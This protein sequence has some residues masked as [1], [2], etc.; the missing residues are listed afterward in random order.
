VVG[1]SSA[2]R[3]PPPLEELGGW[4]AVLR[5]LFAGEVL[6]A[7]VAEAALTDVLSGGAT[8]VQLAAFVGALRARGERVE[9]VAGFV[10][11]MRRHAEQVPV[12]GELVD[13]CGTGGDQSG[14]INVSTVAALVVAAAG[15]RV[16]KHGGRAAS[17]SAGSADVLEALGVVIDLGPAGVARCIEETGIGFCFAPRF[18]PAMRHAAPVRREL[19][20]PTVF[21]LLGPLSNPARATRQV[22]GVGDPALAEVVL[23]ALVANG[24]VHAM[25][26]YGLDGLDELS[27]GAP[28]VVLESEQVAPGRHEQRR[29]E[30]DPSALGIARASR[31]SLRGG[32]A[33]TNAR[34]A[35]EVLGGAPGPHREVVC[36]N[37][38][39]GLLVADA[40]GDWGEALERARA[41][42][43]D[44]SAKRLLERFVESSRRAAEDGLR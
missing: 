14:S 2:S 30:L 7:V 35:L 16:C 10:R 8:P 32:D 19:G 15:V 29:Y 42:I 23:G 20:V 37:A 41:A 18:H 33:A 11:A 34:L 22:V 1:L 26:V 25:V 24:A 5:R 9:E 39:A 6:D 38:A 31:E 43:D 12:E 44:G 36:L 13:T 21:N 28:S 3:E 27:V 17:S 40:C 4:P